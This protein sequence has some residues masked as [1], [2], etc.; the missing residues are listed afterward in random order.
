MLLHHYT[1]H[2]EHIIAIIDLNDADQ[3]MMHSLINL[4]HLLL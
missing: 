1:A 4:S 2:L 3:L